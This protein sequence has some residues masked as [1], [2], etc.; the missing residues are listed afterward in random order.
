MV[1]MLVKELFL[2]FTY[3]GAYACKRNISR[4]FFSSS[5]DV[6]AG[7]RIILAF[8]LM[9]VHMLAKEIFLGVFFSSSVD[10]YAGKRIIL[11][12]LL[13]MVYMLVKELFLCVFF[14][15]I[16]GYASAWRL[17]SLWRNYIVGWGSGP[18]AYSRAAHPIIE[19]PS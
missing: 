17:F 15:S 13:M 6:Y 18:S 12:F 7:K 3:D 9:M 2:R 1:Y 8:L 14:T 5:V 10:V 4:R 16:G 11:A 19:S